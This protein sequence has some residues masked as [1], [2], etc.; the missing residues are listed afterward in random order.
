MA[1]ACAAVILTFAFCYLLVATASTQHP[2]DLLRQLP[3]AVDRQ[4]AT[5]K[6][7]PKPL[8]YVEVVDQQA[9]AYTVLEEEGT[10]RPLCTTS[11]CTRMNAAPSTSKLRRRASRHRRRATRC[12]KAGGTTAQVGRHQALSL[13]PQPLILL[14]DPSRATSSFF[15]DPSLLLLLFFLQS[16]PCQRIFCMPL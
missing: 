5:K 11:L 16:L 7:V 1:C 8:T 9:T 13:Y 12:Q 10:R 2:V 6:L 15:M 4:T 14:M 3:K